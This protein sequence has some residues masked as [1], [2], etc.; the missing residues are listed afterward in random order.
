MSSQTRPHL[1]RAPKNLP[2]SSAVRAKQ[3]L[4]PRGASLT[5]PLLKTRPYYHQPPPPPPRTSDAVSLG[6]WAEDCGQPAF[7]LESLPEGATRGPR[8]TKSGSKTEPPGARRRGAHSPAPPEWTAPGLCPCG[9]TAARR[10]VLLP[11]IPPGRSQRLSTPVCSGPRPP[12]RSQCS[13]RRQ[14]R[15]GLSHA[16]ATGRGGAGKGTPPSQ[17]T[18][19]SLQPFREV[20]S[21]I[22]LA[23]SPRAK[24]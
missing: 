17:D 11:V 3:V 16:A 19:S 14:L 1:P 9:H 13:R 18:H 21:P 12:S 10:V 8:R 4:G 23:V 15:P 22:G 20:G 2:L 6:P 5:F 7:G 24:D